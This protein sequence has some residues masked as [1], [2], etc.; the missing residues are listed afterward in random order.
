[1]QNNA[2]CLNLEGNPSNES[3][4]SPRFTSPLNIPKTSDVSL[5]WLEKVGQ[6]V[7]PFSLDPPVFLI[8]LAVGDGFSNRV[9]VIGPTPTIEV[10]AGSPDSKK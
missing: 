10:Q 3:W 2:E 4:I 8:G 5:F 1:M 7:F 9:P 6:A